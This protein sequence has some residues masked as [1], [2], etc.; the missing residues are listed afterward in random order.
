MKFPVEVVSEY[1]ARRM[2]ASGWSLPVEEVILPI[3]SMNRVK[4]LIEQGVI[5]SETAVVTVNGK[6]VVRCTSMD[7][8]IAVRLC[9][10]VRPTFS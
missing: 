10:Q 4:R 1:G 5:A 6:L 2:N 3:G 9:F 8:E 7:D